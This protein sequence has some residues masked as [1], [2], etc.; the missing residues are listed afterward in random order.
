MIK[1]GKI[2]LDILCLGWHSVDRMCVSLGLSL[3]Q[4]IDCSLREE[5]RR[6]FVKAETALFRIRYL[7][8]SEQE[9]REF[10]RSR[11][12]DWTQVSINTG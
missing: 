12:F 7:D 5:L 11:D 4:T 6:R 9:R 10:C 2:S 3:Q 8:A 1:E